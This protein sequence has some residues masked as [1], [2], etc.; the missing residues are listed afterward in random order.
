MLPFGLGLRGCIG[1]H[2]AMAE[3]S[4]VL[5]ALARRG[6]FTVDGATTEDASFALRVAGGLTGRFT[7]VRPEPSTSQ[8]ATSR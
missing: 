7:P 4:A 3:L 5:P 2:L 1:Q 8:P 6:S